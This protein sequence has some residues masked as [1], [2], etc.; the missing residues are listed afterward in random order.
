MGLLWRPNGW[1]HIKCLIHTQVVF[2][3]ITAY[4]TNISSSIMPIGSAQF[5]DRDWEW[6]FHFPQPSWS[7]GWLWNP[8]LTNRHKGKFAGSF[9]KT[10]S[11]LTEGERGEKRSS[12][13]LLPF[14][15]RNIVTWDCKACTCCSHPVTEVGDIWT[16][17]GWEDR[18]MKGSSV[19][20]G[21][22]ELLSQPWDCLPMA[23]LEREATIIIKPNCLS[24]FY[25]GIQ[26]LAPEAS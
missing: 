10:F 19:F 11:F 26:F 8:V 12:S 13:L 17:W 3:I 18:K 6:Q 23:S 22:I 15:L 14:F 5:Q 4:P 16:L 21:I 25:L 9:W 7:S 24:H 1:M 2:I 20:G